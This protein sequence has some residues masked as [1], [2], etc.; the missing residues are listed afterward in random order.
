MTILNKKNFDTVEA[1]LSDEM[2]DDTWDLVE[3]TPKENGF[4][5]SLTAMDLRVAAILLLIIIDSFGR[6]FTA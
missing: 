2:D 6:N 1:N 3:S 5:S 4:F